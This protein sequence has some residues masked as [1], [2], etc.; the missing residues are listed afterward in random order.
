MSYRPFPRNLMEGSYFARAPLRLLLLWREKPWWCRSWP[1]WWYFMDEADDGAKALM[2]WIYN[3][4]VLHSGGRDV[5]CYQQPVFFV[6][7]TTFEAVPGTSWDAQVEVH[8]YWTEK[9]AVFCFRMV[10][11][12]VS[13]AAKRTEPSNWPDK[14]TAATVELWKIGSDPKKPT[15]RP[16]NRALLVSNRQCP[17]PWFA[18]GGLFRVVENFTW[19]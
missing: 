15:A 11:S 5:L 10:N 18:A 19:G 14:R 12:W 16:I 3:L 1:R 8:D 2:A 17:T 6:S 4:F 9:P 13:L 7:A